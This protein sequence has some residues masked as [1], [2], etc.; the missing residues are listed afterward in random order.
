MNNNQLCFGIDLQQS[1][2]MS[3]Q[4]SPPVKKMKQC[5]NNVTQ[6]DINILKKEFLETVL[7]QKQERHS[8]K[9]KILQLKLQ[10]EL[11]NQEEENTDH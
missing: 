4:D 5:K 9:M 6:N 10:K 2:S 7:K 3:V 11:R 8:I 1:S